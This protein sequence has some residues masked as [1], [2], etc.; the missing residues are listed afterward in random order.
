MFKMKKVVNTL[1]L[2]FLSVWFISVIY[3]SINF[4]VGYFV[5]LNPN[6]AKSVCV[7]SFLGISLTGVYNRLSGVTLKKLTDNVQE[8]KEKQEA[9]KSSCKS[10]K[11]K[12]KN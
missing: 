12:T 4:M 2:V 3:L 10:C 5:D 1:F 7:V 8:F 9:K 11:N 6:I